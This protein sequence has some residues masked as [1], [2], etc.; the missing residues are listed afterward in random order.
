MSTPAAWSC[1]DHLW[2][3]LPRTGSVAASREGTWEAGAGEGVRVSFYSLVFCI[4]RGQR[5]CVTLLGHGS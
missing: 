3:D 5:M 2:K 4:F 1:L